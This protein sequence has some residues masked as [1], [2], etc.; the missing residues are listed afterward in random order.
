[1]VL[2]SVA[3]VVLLSLLSPALSGLSF[4]DGDLDTGEIGGLIEWTVPPELAD[5]T[6][7]VVYLASTNATRGENATEDDVAVAAPTNDTNQTAHDAG[8]LSIR[9]S[10]GRVAVGT[11]QLFVPAD[12]DLSR[13]DSPEEFTSIALFVEKDGVEEKLPR[14]LLTV[15]DVTARADAVDFDATFLGVV[16]LGGTITWSPPEDVSQVTM[17]SV[18]LAKSSGGEKFQFLANVT[19]GTNKLEVGALRALSDPTVTN[20]LVYARSSVAEQT[21]PA[22]AGFGMNTSAASVSNVTF[23]DLDLDQTELGGTVIWIPP[24]DIYLTHAPS[25][26]INGSGTVSLSS[27]GTLE[28]VGTDFVSAGLSSLQDVANS[29][30]YGITSHCITLESGERYIVVKVESP[31]MLQVLSSTGQKPI[32]TPAFNS[33]YHIERCWSWAQTYTVYLA[34]HETGG[35]RSQLGGDIALGTTEVSLPADTPIQSFNH[36]LVYTKSS[37]AGE[38]VTPESTVIVDSEVIVPSISFT[39]LD[40]D[41]GQLGGDVTWESPG[42]RSLVDEYVV[43]LA[44]DPQ[45]SGRSQVGGSVSV[46][47]NAITIV[48]DTASLENQYVLV[49]TKSSLAE[50][51]TP[52]SLELND[53]VA[54]VSSLSFTDKDVDVFEL[55]GTVNW[56][57]P[58]D[59]SQV[60]RYVVYLAVGD[61]LGANRTQIGGDVDIINTS[62]SIP[63]NTALRHYTHV[64]VTTKSSLAESTTPVSTAIS[65]TAAMVSNISFIDLDLDKSELGGTV[66]FNPPE[67]LSEVSGFVVYFAYIETT[68]TT[69]TTTMELPVNLTN[70]TNETFEEMDPTI[71]GLLD[72]NATNVTNETFEDSETTQ[73]TTMLGNTSNDTN[74]SDSSDGGR[75]LSVWAD[76]VQMQVG[77]DLPVGTNEINVPPQTSVGQYSHFLVY[78]KSTLAEAS[79]PD[80]K[81]ISDTVATVSGVEFTDKDLDKAELGGTIVWDPPEDTAQVN[82]YVVYLAEGPA[83]EG[84]VILIDGTVPANQTEVFIPVGTAKKNFTHVLVYTKSTLV[85]QSTPLAADINDTDAMVS[86]VLFTDKDLDPNQIGGTVTWVAPG[87]YQHVTQYLVYLA[88]TGSDVT[89]RLRS[90]VGVALNVGTNSLAVPADTSLLDYNRIAV[91]TKSSLVEQSTP[92]EVTVSDIQT[93]ITSVDF[94]DKDLDKAELGGTVKW[95]LEGDLSEVEFYV[96]YLASGVGRMTPGVPCPEKPQVDSPSPSPELLV[97][98]NGTNRT[99]ATSLAGSAGGTGATGN[100]SALAD[101][102]SSNASSDE[103]AAAPGDSAPS[104]TPGSLAKNLSNVTNATLGNISGT[105]AAIESGSADIA[106]AEADNRSNASCVPIPGEPLPFASLRLLGK[107]ASNANQELH[108]PSNT[109][110]RNDTHLVVF[111][112]SVL[113]EQTT[114]QMLQVNDTMASVQDVGFTDKDLD[115]LELGGTVTWGPPDDTSEVAYYVVYFAYAPPTS[116]AKALPAPSKSVDA[117]LWA[118]NLSESNA[119]NFTMGMEYAL[120][121]N[122]SNF[123]TVSNDTYNIT[124]LKSVPLRSQVGTVPVG[125]NHLDITTNT[126][127][128]IYT[129]IVVYTQSSLT[130]Q[131]TPKAVTFNDTVASAINV[132]FTDLDLDTGELGGMVTWIPE[133]D[134][135]EVMYYVAYLAT[136]ADGEGCGSN[137]YKC[138]QI[139][140]DVEVGTNQI[141]IPK[142]TYVVLNTQVIVYVPAP[143]PEPEMVSTEMVDLI[144]ETNFT[145]ETFVSEVVI[146]AVARVI[147]ASNLTNA[148]GFNLTEIVE[149]ALAALNDSN[150]TT[151]STSTTT[152]ASTTTTTEAVTEEVNL[153]NITNATFHSAVAEAIT[154]AVARLNLTNITNATIAAAVTSAVTNATSAG[155][156]GN[157]TNGT[158]TTSTST[159]TTS[160]TTT[161][162]VNV[163]NVTNATVIAADADV[164]ASAGWGENDT[165]PVVYNVTFGP[166]THIL[167]YTKSSLT[168]QSSPSALMAKDESASVSEV[169]YIGKDLDPGELGG[170]IRWLPPPDIRLVQEYLVYVSLDFRGVNRSQVGGPLGVGTNQIVVDAD[171]EMGL[172][173][174][175]LV[176]TK[177]TLTEQT[178]PVYGTLRETVA[179]V[180]NI[181]FFDEDLDLGQIGGVVQWFPPEDVEQVT[182]YVVYLSMD[183]NHLDRSIVDIN[184][185]AGT[186]QLDIPEDTELAHY[187]HIAVYARS[188]LAEQTTPKFVKTLDI[189]GSAVEIGF[190]DLDLD[191]DD[192]GGMITWKEPSYP[193]INLVTHYGVYLATDKYGT[194]RIQLCSTDLNI[195]EPAI[196]PPEE[197]PDLPCNE[198]EGRPCPVSYIPPP[199]SNLTNVTNET[200][201]SVLDEPFNLTNFT[202]NETYFSTFVEKVNFSNIT[203]FTDDRQL[204]NI[205]RG[206]NITPN[207]SVPVQAVTESVEVAEQIEEA[208]EKEVNC[209]EPGANCT[210]PEVHE[211][212][213]G[214]FCDNGTIA[215]L[216]GVFFVPEAELVNITNVTNATLADDLPPNISEFVPFIEK[217]CDIPV[218]TTFLELIAD[219]TL[220]PY[221][222]IV[223]YAKRKIGP[224]LVWPNFTEQSTPSAHIINETESSVDSV[225]WNATSE[226]VSWVPPLDTTY[227]VTYVVYFAFEAGGVD[228]MQ[229]GPVI[230]LGTNE[231]SVPFNT[232]AG[233]RNYI[234]VYTK[235]T[236]AE[237]TTPA[238]GLFTQ[239]LTGSLQFGSEPV[240]E[241]H[242]HDD[243]VRALKWLPNLDTGI[244][245]ELLASGSAD[246]TVK[247]WN[248]GPGSYN[249]VAA[250]G[251]V[252]SLKGHY[253]TVWALEWIGTIGQHTLLAS[254]SSDGTIRLWPLDVITTQQ[255]CTAGQHWS[256]TDTCCDGD[257]LQCAGKYVLQADD[258]NFTSDARPKVRA[259]LW[260]QSYEMLASAWTDQTV[261]F[262]RYTGGTPLFLHIRSYYLP[263]T[264]FSL[265]WIPNR[266]RLVTSSPDD[267][268][269][270]L[271]ELGHWVIGPTKTISQELGEGGYGICPYGHCDSVWFVKYAGVQSLVRNRAQYT[272]ATCSEDHMVKLW[273]V[274]TGERLWNLPRDDDSGQ[275]QYGH[276]SPVRVLEFLGSENAIAA[277]DENGKVVLWNPQSGYHIQTLHKHT[278]TVLAVQWVKSLGRLV[279]ASKD[280]TIKVY[281]CKKNDR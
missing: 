218:G 219:T 150:A 225:E 201:E 177:S 95:T 232:A 262:W 78:T 124:Y 39:D 31:T 21:T 140:K 125:T 35:N 118:E 57:A 72:P 205:T 60:T 204:F 82:N 16:Q 242:G 213:T 141:S 166:Y 234:L 200:A 247:I 148:T 212:C 19:V 9:R 84:R 196:P 92:A 121:G 246:W 224:D 237:Q 266:G 97:E 29:T 5:N 94:T 181:T 18:Y 133:G 77:G 235:S 281:E 53:T 189:D 68:T 215:A 49:Y 146:S 264:P 252:N 256:A 114:P 40:L 30:E 194:D 7:Y 276:T 168:E 50:Q 221:T 112:R 155:D 241:L 179:S 65:D 162:L 115:V 165:I 220:S 102:N 117:W 275:A 8:V 76:S 41:Q 2:C 75:R 253:G 263:D 1:M 233:K 239:C 147:N 54:F 83:G 109:P 191:I 175:A 127:F 203:N 4:T 270:K 73:T 3:G 89:G 153:T 104:P 169:T 240:M 129:Q 11:H 274:G 135:D 171:T 90:Q 45:G 81:S 230:P 180:S 38:Q 223:I 132:S 186:N 164:V 257:G 12:T 55:G 25:S 216:F 228:R 227:V 214:N 85:E 255:T 248:A 192:L 178:T 244:G 174:Y 6:H 170:S 24:A 91:Y 17:Y 245:V 149:E 157:G 209:S 143:S 71:A 226:I 108:I 56:V 113:A 185:S 278:D 144:N 134:T 105:V 250:G 238:I 259:L 107:V 111:A 190:E 128:G 20:I 116:E 182:D 142:D 88:K 26:K 154:S 159:T 28:G 64:L 243:S 14:F 210:I 268:L 23:I 130:E 98:S 103:A 160:T 86:S 33:S 145:N 272:L 187:T 93:S 69:T 123:T 136:D 70:V 152:A 176:Y 96:V 188:A 48:V 66:M 10:L 15:V 46:G 202:E 139:G 208:L 67:D 236:L 161:L 197:I 13:S 217:D 44:A 110:L 273:D 36:F 258:A 58:S 206:P 279:T 195:S 222:H 138:A 131:T 277:G 198:T 43:F 167:V 163:T 120:E 229:Y 231:I 61:Y 267:V 183:E 122:V 52:Q 63:I 80:T 126:E 151:T 99:N 100:A 249:G 119:S 87:D 184:C 42:D 156:D 106:I 158:T 172:N 137:E 199:P 32:A 27:D 251:L 51:T 260:I 34:E 22:Y 211:N 74:V 79:T 193:H 62:I 101:D 269:A 261:K 265:S 37:M 254:A 271:W 173:R 207:V 280:K 59:I 47:T